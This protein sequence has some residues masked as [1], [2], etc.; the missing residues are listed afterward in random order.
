MTQEAD[1]E[2]SLPR[3]Q[4]GFYSQA[5]GL[6]PWDGAEKM[7]RGLTCP[8]E[9]CSTGWLSCYFSGTGLS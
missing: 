6:G 8:L 9:L 4:E 1:T 7:A 2:I 5:Q 3:G